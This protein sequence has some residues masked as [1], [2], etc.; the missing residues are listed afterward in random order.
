VEAVIGFQLPVKKIDLERDFAERIDDDFSDHIFRRYVTRLLR[1]ESWRK[2]LSGRSEYGLIWKT[3]IRR[4]AGLAG[5]RRGPALDAAGIPEG[6]NSTFLA[7]WERIAGRVR[8]LWVYSEIEGARYDFERVFEQVCLAG[9]DR[10][11]EKVVLSDSN[12][13]FAPDTA[14]ESLLAAIDDWLARHYGAAAGVREAV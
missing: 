7:A 8:L 12:H 4:L 2:F 10:P 1:P 13:E 5:L 3:A 6:M 11:Y 9:R 14:Q